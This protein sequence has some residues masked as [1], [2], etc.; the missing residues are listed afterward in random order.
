MLFSTIGQNYVFL[1]MTCAGLLVGALYALCAGLRRLLEAGFWLT[2]LIDVLF[3]L[4]AGT[5]LI[6]ALVTGSYGAVRLYELL[7]VALGVVL[8]ELGLAPVIRGVLEALRRIVR[9]LYDA[10]ANFRLIKVIF[11]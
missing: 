2:L 7:G 10:V 4:G 11:K 1:W 9:R 6:A 8:F 3:G 5:I